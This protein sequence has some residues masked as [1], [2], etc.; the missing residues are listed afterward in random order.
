MKIFNLLSK[1]AFL[2]FLLVAFV[3]V[4]CKDDDDETPGTVDNNEIV[5]KWQLTAVEP[6]NSSTT[7]PQ[8]SLL[9]TLAPCY[10]ELKF[11]FTNDNKVTLSDCDA[12]VALIGAFVNIAADTK[13]KVET[14]KLTLTNGS[15]S[16]TFGLT[17]NPNDM[18]I[19]VN[20]NTTGTGTPVNAVMSLK[21]L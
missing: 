2:S 13:W 18:K 6:E 19:V 3:F 7:I 1:T 21:R 12:A 17:Q 10:K 9:P 16:N 5:G 11:T 8:L 15:T 4:S 14:G 20:T